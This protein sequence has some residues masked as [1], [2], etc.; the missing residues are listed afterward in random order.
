[1]LWSGSQRGEHWTTKLLPFTTKPSEAVCIL[2]TGATSPPHIPC[3]FFL[4]LYPGPA[5]PEQLL[6]A[7]GTQQA[8]ITTE[9]L[10]S[11]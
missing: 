3:S 8:V 6:L 9:Q 4:P 2:H 1:M 10:P 5:T 11:P 7:L